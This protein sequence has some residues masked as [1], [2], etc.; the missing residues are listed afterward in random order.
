MCWAS[1]RQ[2]GTRYIAAMP[3]NLYG[4]GDNYDAQNS[5]VLPA[6]IRKVIGAKARGQKSI[7]VW[8]S[9]TPRRE[10]LHS[11]DLAEACL[12]LLEMDDTGLA[13]LLRDDQPPLVNIGAGYDLTIRELAELICQIFKFDGELVFDVSKPD[14]TPR[15]LMDS[16]LL[17]SL[18]WTPK[19][20][21]EAGIRG[22]NA[23]SF[24]TDCVPHQHATPILFPEKN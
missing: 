21:L 17:R 6:L 8:G 14:G 9:G 5:H 18:G 2:Y 24:L 19:I 7:E 13:A 16:S 4:P 1:N 22:L 10:F 15:K 3:T 12:H 11:D 20:E 23:H